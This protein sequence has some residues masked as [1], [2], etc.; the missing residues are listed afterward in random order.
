MRYLVALIMS[1]A[2]LQ[3]ANAG[4]MLDNVLNSTK[5]LDDGAYGCDAIPAINDVVEMGYGLA[6]NA[7][8]E[9][10]KSTFKISKNHCV[11]QKRTET[12]YAAFKLYFCATDN[13]CSDRSAG[14]Q[15]VGIMYARRFGGEFSEIYVL[16]KSDIRAN[17]CTLNSKEMRCPA[18]S[19]WEQPDRGPIN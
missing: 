11:F 17:H 12:K 3:S 10:A 4:A 15:H 9:A 14:V 5:A 13:V 18:H 2:S 6:R 7:L 16:D 8:Q 1:V 19:Q